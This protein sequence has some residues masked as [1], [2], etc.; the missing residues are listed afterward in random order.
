VTDPKGPSGREGRFFADV[1]SFGWVLP[2]SIAAGAG[3]GWLAD[4]FLG[5]FPVLTA[6]LGLLGLAAGL[7]AVLKEAAALS[8]DAPPGPRDGRGD[9]DRK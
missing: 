4:R 2:A 6:V 9:G 1:L 5:I 8:G 7:R 3:L